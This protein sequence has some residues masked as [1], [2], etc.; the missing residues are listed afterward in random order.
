MKET[1]EKYESYV[2]LV[3]GEW[4]KVKIEVRGAQARL[5]VHDQPQP[6]LIVNDLKTGAAM[7]G[8]V[9][10]WHGHR[11][12]GALP[13]PHRDAAIGIAMIGMLLQDLRQALRTLASRPGFTTAAILS[14]ALAIGAETSVYALI[15]ALFD[16][17]PIG[18]V[19]PRELVA[20]SAFT[21]GKPVEDEI[22]FP[23]YLYL[24]DHQTVFSALASHFSSGVGLFDS[25]R[26]EQLNG[27][28]V[29]ANYFSVLGLT[30]R[31]GRFFL[32]EEDRVPDRDAVIVLSHSYW[33]RRFDGD[34]RCVGQTI[35]LNG[36]PFTVIGVAP[37]G[38]EVLKS[39]GLAMSSSRT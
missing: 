35:T 10:L 19:E 1:P 8:G 14:L 21:K 6:T 28:V 12:G 7:K 20:I 27:H 11:H 29:S 24:R 32:P 23:D 38:F 30:P 37:A 25:E 2:D 18:V 36:V 13:K 26:A 39:A 17:P 16:R 9:A 4:T 22:R 15:R 3:P 34:A 33:Q 31:L 5:Y